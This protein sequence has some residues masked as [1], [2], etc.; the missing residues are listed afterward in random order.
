MGKHLLEVL[1]V[2]FQLVM[3]HSLPRDGQAFY[4]NYSIARRP[5]SFLVRVERIDRRLARPRTDNMTS[6]QKV[7]QEARTVCEDSS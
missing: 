7:K 4:N 2:R 3:I 5:T 1:D 6:S